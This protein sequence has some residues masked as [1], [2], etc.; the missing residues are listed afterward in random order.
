MF[1]ARDRPPFN[2]PKRPRAAAAALLS[3]FVSLGMGSAVTFATI[4][5]TS[6]FTSLDFVP[7]RLRMSPSCHRLKGDWKSLRV[8][9]DP[10][11]HFGFSYRLRA[12]K[13]AKRPTTHTDEREC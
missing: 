9:T 4:S 8:Q 7:E 1:A 11:R 5:A 3:F 2:P 12:S 6:W 10:L 13:R